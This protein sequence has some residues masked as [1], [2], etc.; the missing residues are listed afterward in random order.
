MHSS[1]TIAQLAVQ[2]TN[3]SGTGTVTML[4]CGVT[5]ITLKVDPL[6][7]LTGEYKYY[8]AWDCDPK[9]A[10]ITGQAAGGRL[11]LDVEGVGRTTL[12][13]GGAA[14]A[15]PPAAAPAAAQPSVAA[16]AP[17]GPS[18]SPDGLWRGT[19]A[20]T[21]V[22]SNTSP[23]SYTLDLKLSLANGISSGGGVIP[24]SSNDRTMEIRVSVNPPNVT[25][26]RTS[27]TGTTNPAPQRNSFPGQFDGTSIR[28]S[29]RTG[30]GSVAS[31]SAAAYD[32]TLTL[33]RA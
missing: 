28:A 17:A 1:G 26:T 25:V 2:M 6:G 8:N 20:C 31:V 33:T 12:T 18:T 21:A 10:R 22:S 4:N 13:L 14:P 3:G 27:L 7:N 24:T 32:C 9:V 16:V 5:P 15:S 11:T 23:Q 30:I 19:Y 29:G